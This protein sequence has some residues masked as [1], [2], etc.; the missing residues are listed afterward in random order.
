MD[1]RILLAVCFV[2]LFLVIFLLQQ[3]VSNCSETL[4]PGFWTVS[5]QF[6][7]QANID[8]LVLYFDEGKGYEYKGYMVMVVDGETLFNETLNFMITPKGYFKSDSYEFVT[9]K[10]T[11]IMPKKMTM[12]LCSRDGHMELK[13]LNTNKIY[14]QLFKDNQM[15]AK[16]VLSVCEE[17][18]D[19]EKKTLDYQSKDND[20]EV[21]DVIGDVEALD[22][23]GDD[24]EALD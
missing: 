22:A 9:E 1:P 19:D 17:S 18:S 11:N 2:L 15:S 14:A 5:E 4:I 16:T 3:V 6:K 10:N 24:V 7:E 13:C 8:Q 21:L 12:E 20:V 23:I